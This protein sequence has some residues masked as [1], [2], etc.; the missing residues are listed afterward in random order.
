M[1]VI[2]IRDTF[3]PKQFYRKLT[4]LG[5][6]VVYHSHRAIIPETGCHTNAWRVYFSDAAIPEQL[7]VHQNMLSLLLL[8]RTRE[9]CRLGVEFLV[10][11]HQ[12]RKAVLHLLAVN[13][14]LKAV[15]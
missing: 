2:G 6:D 14:P 7:Q 3:E 11:M 13:D 8:I 10:L 5:V 15:V 9:P 12:R 1:D 4:Q